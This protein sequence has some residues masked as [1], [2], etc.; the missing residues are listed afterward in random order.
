M[1]KYR[2]TKSQVVYYSIDV[3]VED[4]ESHWDAIEFA[5]QIDGG[6]WEESGFTDWEDE[7]VEDLETGEVWT[8]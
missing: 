7:S 1:K 5:D 2:V 8:F 3:E 4:N 6:S